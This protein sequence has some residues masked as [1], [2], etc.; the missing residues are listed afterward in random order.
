M[1]RGTEKEKKINLRLEREALTEMRN[2]NLETKIIEKLGEMM[3]R[4]RNPPSL[5]K[6]S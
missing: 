4:K 2:Q 3:H 1:G 5:G 6:R